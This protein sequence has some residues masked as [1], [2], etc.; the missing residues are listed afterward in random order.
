MM[1]VFLPTDEEVKEVLQA[2]SL[3]VAHHDR[4]PWESVFKTE[5]GGK[6]RVAF[7]TWGDTQVEEC[8]LVA[9]TDDESGRELLASVQQTHLRHRR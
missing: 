2:R 1:N 6:T 3:Q 7:L 4:L 8:Q 5:A 9:V